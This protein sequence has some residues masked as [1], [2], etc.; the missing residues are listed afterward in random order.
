[1]RLVT[2]WQKKFSRKLKKIIIKKNLIINKSC[3]FQTHT[4]INYLNCAFEGRNR[5]AVGAKLEEVSLGYGSYI[6]NNSFILQT[7]I[8]RYCSIAPNVR[9]IS[10]A[11]PTTN[12]VSSHPAFFSTRKQCGFSYVNK[13]LFEE[14][15]YADVNHHALVC[16][17]NDVWIGDS[18]MIM[19]GVTIGDGA[20]IAAGAVVTQNV[21]PY[22][23]VGGVPAKLIRKRFD[24]KTIEK[25]L[26]D[27]WWNKSE[28][29]IREHSALFTS[30]D[31]YFEGK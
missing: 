26:A 20:V 9:I 27:K 22:S 16:I 8:G 21:A 2:K 29:W 10:G 4:E 1:M 5:V 13:D 28:E 17:G 31:S 11:H 25:L 6:G 19:Q 3:I 18:A 7:Q 12:Y 15:E 24:E 23:I 30:V 14:F